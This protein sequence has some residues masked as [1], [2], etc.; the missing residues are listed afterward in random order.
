MAIASSVRRT[1]CSI[2]GPPASMRKRGYGGVGNLGAPPKPPLVGSA[3]R[4]NAPPTCSAVSVFPSASASPAAP[5][6]GSAI[7]R[8]TMS[9]MRFACSAMPARSDFHA[10]STARTRSTND[11]RPNAGCGGKYVPQK[12]GSSVCGSRNTLSGQP[13]LERPSVSCVNTWHAVIMSSSTSGRCS[14]STLTGTHASFRTPAAI[15]L[16]KLSRSITWHQ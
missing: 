11:G 5:A 9:A 2:A 14:R 1:T 4:S 16:S 10:P 12:K 7:C 6:V 13:P 8:R 15:T 3:M